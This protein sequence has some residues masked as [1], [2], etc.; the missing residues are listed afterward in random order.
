MLRGSPAWVISMKLV[1]GLSF[2]FARYSNDNFFALQAS[3]FAAPHQLQ[4]LL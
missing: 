3:K 4:C 1:S 2:C